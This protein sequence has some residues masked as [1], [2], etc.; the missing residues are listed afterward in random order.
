MMAYIEP[1]NQD[2]EKCDYRGRAL[3]SGIVKKGTDEQTSEI[4]HG[5]PL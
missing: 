1:I 2:H 5:H 3:T 4:L